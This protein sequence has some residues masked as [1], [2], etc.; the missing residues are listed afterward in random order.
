MG[1]IPRKLHRLARRGKPAFHLG[2]DRDILEES[3]QGFHDDRIALVP[4]VV[5]DVFA[6]QAGADE[7]TD[8]SVRRCRFPDLGGY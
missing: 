2:A 3:P 1:G 4:A 8:R 6:E 5:A 7:D